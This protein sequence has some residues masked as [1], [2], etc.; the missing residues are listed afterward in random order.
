MRNLAY[1]AKQCKKKNSADEELSE[2]ISS[3][4]YNKQC[5]HP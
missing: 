3:R 2:I 4:Y 1:C 5:P